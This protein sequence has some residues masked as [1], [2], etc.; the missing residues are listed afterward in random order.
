MRVLQQIASI[1]C[2]A[3]IAGS[4]W[5]QTEEQLGLSREM[6]LLNGFDTMTQDMAR[7]L[8]SPSEDTERGDPAMARAWAR[9]GPNFFDPDEMFD[10]AAQR[11]AEAATVEELEQLKTFF[12]TELGQKVTALEEASQAPEMADV[13]TIAAGMRLLELQDDPERLAA[14]ERLS[15]AFGSD[16]A[17]AAVSLNVQFAFVSALASRNP[18]ALPEADLL[19]LIMGGHDELVAEIRAEAVPRHAF[20][21]Q[22]LTIEEIEA[23]AEL[24]ETPAGQKMYAAVNSAL[25]GEMVAE[26]RAFGTLLG[27][28]LMAEDI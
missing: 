21:Y 19:A 23:Y 10:A 26:I 17:A 12:A 5:A 4:A 9:I 27:A 25:E 16:E 15:A 11:L 7:D 28:A 8:R 1:A 24:L 2:A 6:L 22:D 18:N 3:L 14:L 20:V 13:D